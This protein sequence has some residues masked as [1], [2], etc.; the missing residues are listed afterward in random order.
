MARNAAKKMTTATRYP[1]MRSAASAMP[2]GAHTA[3]ALGWTMAR[4]RPILAV[5]TY[6]ASRPSL[7]STV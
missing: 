4:L 1:S 2:E 3:V 7:V 6:R 5:T